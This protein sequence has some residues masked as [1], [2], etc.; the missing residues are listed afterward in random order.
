MTTVP[1]A[2]AR[3]LPVQRV[4]R[5]QVGDCDLAI[6]RGA[7]GQVQAWENRCPHRGMRLSYGFI[8]G[9]SLACAYHGW[10]YNTEAVCH[11]I[12]AHPELEPPATIKPVVYS[13]LE[14]D[15]LL[16]VN[17]LAQAVVPE[18][19]Q[20]CVGVRSI[21]VD[22]EASVALKEIITMTFEDESAATLTARQIGD[23]PMVLSFGNQQQSDSV[24]LFFQPS[25][26]TRVVLH[27]VANQRWSI[28]GRVGI[29]K[30]CEALRRSVELKFTGQTLEQS[31]G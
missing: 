21:S 19:P 15:G 16:W 17:T 31:P 10:H 28:A 3:D 6:W 12:P 27:V 25:G 23:A 4:M 24:V 29:S 26:A 11:Y 7:S 22:C 2:L 20:D 5:A 13:V 14:Q 8:R 9:D 30:W 18:L 1:V